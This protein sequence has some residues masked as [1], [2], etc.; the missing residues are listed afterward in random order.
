MDVLQVSRKATDAE[1]MVLQI[2]HDERWA[3][4]QQW[5]ESKGE[6]IRRDFDMSVFKAYIEI[7]TDEQ[8][9]RGWNYDFLVY[10]LD[11]S[12]FVVVEPNQFQNRYV[13][14]RTF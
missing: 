11:Q 6:T 1:A 7:S 10:D 12:R 9:I 2:D 3:Q 4:I 13:A 8:T 14:R 5:V